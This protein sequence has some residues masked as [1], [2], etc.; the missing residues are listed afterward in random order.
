MWKNERTALMCATDILAR[1]DHSECRLRQKLIAKEYPADEINEAIEKLK[2]Y[3]YLN[4]Q[5]SCE[6]QFDIM[7]NSNRYSIRQIRLKLVKLGFDSNLIE[8]CKPENC[9]EHDE[10]VAE[11]LLQSRFKVIPEDKKMWNFLSSKGFDYSI[12]SFVVNKFKSDA[13]YEE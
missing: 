10:I 3:N 13:S 6:N 1:Q 4:D 8:S 9:D 5:R 11:L 12:I 2:K 7:Y